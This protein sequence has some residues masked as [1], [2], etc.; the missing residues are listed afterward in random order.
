MW[1]LQ[2]LS[3]IFLA[4]VV[5]KPQSI[6]EISND[7]RELYRILGEKAPVYQQATSTIR[8][9][10]V[11]PP[12]SGQEWTTN[13]V[14][15]ADAAL[16]SNDVL[17]LFRNVATRY[18]TEKPIAVYLPGLDGFGISAATYQ[19]DDLSRAFELWRMSIAIEDRTS[20]GD[21]LRTVCQFI[22]QVSSTTDRPVYLIAESFGGLLA[23]AVSLQLQK[24]YERDGQR[25]NPLK[26]LV[27]VNPATSFDESNWDTLA[28]ALSL[29]G[30]LTSNTPMP[31]GLPSPYSVVGG[32]MLSALIPSSEQNQRILQTIFGLESLRQPTGALESIQGMLES[33]RITAEVLPP[34]LLQHRIQN[35]MIVGSALINPRLSQLTVPTLIVVGTEDK[36]IASGREVRRLS[37]TLPHCET[38]EVRGAGHFVLDDNVNLTEAMVYSKMLDPLGRIQKSSNNNKTIKSYDPILDWKPPSKKLTDQVREESVKPLEDAFSPIFISTDENGNKVFGLDNLPKDGPLLFVSNHQLCKCQL[39]MMFEINILTETMGLVVHS[40]RSYAWTI[41]SF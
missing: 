40:R 30:N 22:E 4:G 39:D 9:N 21:L 7:F 11:T 1:G 2:R 35:W 36:L 34:G 14:M 18:G 32:L 27:L 12:P 17:G 25:T 29:F 16:M 23:P 41:D 28:P 8:F 3:T 38:L 24:K 6:R 31:L 19:F 10:F 26:G 5:T 20:Y 37:K 15:L 33:F 13:D